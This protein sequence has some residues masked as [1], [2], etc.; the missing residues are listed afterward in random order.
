MKKIEAVIRHHK[1]DD[2]RAAL[3]N[4]GVHGM[5]V[6]EVRGSGNAPGHVEVYRG[7]EYAVD[8]TPRTKVE[9][10]VADAA[11]QATVQ[12]IVTAARTGQIGDGRVMITRLAEVVRV[13]TGET[14]DDAV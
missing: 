4:L 13:R 12:A 7:Q 8:F 3:V 9:V 11:C 10:I 2:V 14:G 1:L 6:S 5:T